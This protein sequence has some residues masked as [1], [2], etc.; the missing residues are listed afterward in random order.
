MH[1]LLYSYAMYIL[2]KYT[3]YSIDYNSYNMVTSSNSIVILNIDNCKDMLNGIYWE[4]KCM[5]IRY[6]NECLL[7]SV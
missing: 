2:Y 1:W 6:V 3:L 5:V 4:S 7:K